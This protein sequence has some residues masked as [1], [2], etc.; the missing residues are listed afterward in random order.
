MN[1]FDAGY[2]DYR[3]QRVSNLADLTIQLE[4]CIPENGQR[5]LDH[6][7]RSLD[8]SVRLILRNLEMALV[9]MIEE[10][11][12]VVG[13]V[14]W[15]TSEPILRALAEI[16]GTQIV[17]QKEDFLRPDLDARNLWK[18]R[19]RKLYDNLRMPLDRYGFPEP[20]GG[21]SYC[22][23]PTVEPVRCVG[24]HNASKSAAFPRAHHKFV[25]FCRDGLEPYAVW[26]GTFNFTKN[27]GASLENAL[28]LT[29]PNIVQAFFDEWAQLLAISEPLDWRS[30]W[31]VPEWR[32]GS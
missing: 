19:L 25:V 24:N 27:A 6:S 29:D 20:V 3:T 30:T 26:T 16:K 4:H 23:D 28:V 22:A 13:C 8:G 15:L 5:L 31:V 7:T 1:Y 17:V 10:A 14:A 32:I 18:R 11:D 2:D 21:M 12:Y 9:E